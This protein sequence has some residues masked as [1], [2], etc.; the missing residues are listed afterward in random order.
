V[1][2]D[3][4]DAMFG[5][6]ANTD[7]PVPAPA[8][9]LARGRQ[10]RRRARVRAAGL[11]ATVVVA[12]VVGVT[13]LP[14]AGQKAPATGGHRRP[15][16]TV[17]TA[18]PDAALSS[19][20]RRDLPASSQLAVSPLALSPDGADL[21]A[22]TTDG[23]FHGIAEESVAT[24]AILV[25][26]EQIPA[27][28]TPAQGGLGPD[29]ELIWS[30][31]YARTEHE[32]AGTT[33]VELW[34]PRTG[35][36]S[37]LEPAGLSGGAVSDLV[38][39]GSGH[40][41]AAWLEQSGGKQEVVEADLLTGRTAVIASGQVGPPVFVGDALVW[42]AASD[43]T[44]PAT[45]LVATDAAGFPAEQQVPVPV[46]LRA[47]TEGALMG[48]GPAGSW[49]TPVGLI[50]SYGQ[51]T[52]Y[53]S[54]DLAGLYYSPSPSQPARLVLAVPGGGLAAGPPVLGQGYLGWSTDTP[55]SSVASTSSLAAVLLI[56]G[57]TTWGGVQGLG[58][59]LWADISPPGKKQHLDHLYVVS[60]STIAGLTCQ[61]RA[62]PRSK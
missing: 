21:Y 16:S 11:A 28:D 5:K 62:K 12:I 35:R 58:D 57:N 33:P 39:Y 32:T 38:F 55:T 8:G 37:E 26:I 18:A 17:C 22:E 31:T 15:P 50:A 4:L 43:P 29:G 23:T 51:Q 14:G 46:A 7:L 60:G 54:P 42:P 34:S 44:G 47:V 48:S 1:A 2:E 9:V 30:A 53:Y 36:I 40:Q 45:H 59:Y 24:G 49:P 41:Y 27:A 10:R 19:A 25:K 6:L 56:N 20:L 52:A 61:S 13:Q 3:P